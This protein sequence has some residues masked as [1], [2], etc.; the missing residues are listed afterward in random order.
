MEAG[1]VN[2]APPLVE[3]PPEAPQMG[4]FARI[5]RVARVCY[6]S[7]ADRYDAL[8]QNTHKYMAIGESV[9]ALSG[10]LAGTAEAADM[11][12]NATPVAAEGNVPALTA[13]AAQSGLKDQCAS[14][15]FKKGQTQVIDSEMGHPGQK[16]QDILIRLGFGK[17]R[18]ACKGFFMRLAAVKPQI[19]RHGKT[20]N[21][22]PV[23]ADLLSGDTNQPTVRGED[24][25]NSSQDP[26]LFYHKGDKVRFKLRLQEYSVKAKKIVKTVITNHPVKVGH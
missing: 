25:V 23:F 2:Q 4:V 11:A 10:G 9:L 8:R 6:E 7:A 3:A 15:I 16:N 24:Y 21:E 22:S 17:V 12:F 26:K 18:D 19:I 13:T 14:D 5:G 1:T 20:I